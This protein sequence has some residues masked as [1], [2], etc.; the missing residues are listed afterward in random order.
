MS[1]LQPNRDL[2]TQQ[3]QPACAFNPNKVKPGKDY[4]NG[5]FFSLLAIFLYVLFFYKSMIRNTK[6]EIAATMDMNHFSTAQVTYLFALMLLMMFER[7]LYRI[8]NS[9]WGTESAQQ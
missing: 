9:H 1:K 2:R 7:M 8:R 5:N 3:D 6:S 4:F